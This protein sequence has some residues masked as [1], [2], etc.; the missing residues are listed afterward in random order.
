M[1]ASDLFVWDEEKRAANLRKHR[2]DFTLVELF[3][4]ANAVII[5]DD[6]RDYGEVRHRAFGAISGRFYALVFTRRGDRIRII[7]LRKANAKEIIRYAS[8]KEKP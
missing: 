6:R 5:A 3:D 4:F 8:T 2:V 1:A 7:S